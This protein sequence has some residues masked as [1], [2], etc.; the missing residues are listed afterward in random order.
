MI[1][2]H[3]CDKKTNANGTREERERDRQMNIYT[4]IQRCES[5]LLQNLWRDIQRATVSID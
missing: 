4:Q 3:G 5:W 2:H 1:V